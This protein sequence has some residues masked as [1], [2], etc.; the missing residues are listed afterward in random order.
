[1]NVDLDLVTDV[2]VVAGVF[3]DAGNRPGT[4]QRP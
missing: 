1:M 3:V 4:R 2:V